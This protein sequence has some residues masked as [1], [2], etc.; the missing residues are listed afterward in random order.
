MP[1]ELNKLKAEIQRLQ[2]EVENL[3]KKRS[4]VVLSSSSSPQDEFSA[5]STKVLGDSSKQGRK[6]DAEIK[7]R[8]TNFDREDLDSLWRI[9]HE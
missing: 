8:N 3:K 4:K 7:G 6:S 9:V 1:S 2:N 5:S